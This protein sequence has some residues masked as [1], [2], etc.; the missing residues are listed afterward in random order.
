[1]IEIISEKCVEV[2]PLSTESLVAW[3]DN[4]DLRK[5][6]I[7]MYA[8]GDYSF[9][10]EFRFEEGRNRWQI[11]ATTFQEDAEN[12]APAPAAENQAETIPNFSND[13]YFGL[14]AKYSIAWEAATSAVLSESAHFSLAHVLESETELQA[15]ILLASQIYYKQALQMLRNFLEGI[16]LQL[17]FCE[18]RNDF[19]RWK[20]GVYKVPPLRGKDGLISSLQNSGLLP[21]D[22]SKSASDL[23]G[24]LNGSIHGAQGRLINTGVF[25]GKWAG[26]IF[27]YDRFREW[28]EYFSRCVEIGIHILRISTNL[29][30]EKRPQGRV[31]C[32]V[33]H[34]ENANE[35]TIDKTQVHEGIISFTCN[36]CGNEQHFTAEWAIRNGY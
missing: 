32:D 30:Q 2:L 18:N 8:L 11:T 5:L 25:E 3:D 1:M 24:D 34:N 6:L 27:K 22:L 35:F 28:C 12:V 20:T 7:E 19:E 14:M 16:I 36:R 33:C 9:Y 15:S 4:C 23:Y 26:Q 21:P 17:H 13:E 29:W 31:Y 10:G